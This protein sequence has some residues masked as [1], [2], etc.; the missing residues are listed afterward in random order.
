ML[1]RDEVYKVTEGMLKYG[2]NFEQQLGKLLE[3]ADWS[4]Q[5][6]IKKA[7]PEYWRKYKEMG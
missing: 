6:K 3:M 4:N 2:G 5:E 1:D 7:W